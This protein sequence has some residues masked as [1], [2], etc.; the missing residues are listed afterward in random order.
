MTTRPAVGLLGILS[1]PSDAETAAHHEAYLGHVGQ[2][3]AAVTDIIS[4]RPVSSEPELELSIEE[5]ERVGAHGIALVLLGAGQSNDCAE[6]LARTHL[7]LLLV[8]VQPERTVS[9]DWSEYDLH[10]NR[11]VDAVQELA[12]RLVRSRMSFSVI[13]GDWLSDR[14]AAAFE[15]WALA[16]RT[17]PTLTAAPLVDLP[18]R[19]AETLL[20]EAVS[21]RMLAMD[22]NRDAVLLAPDRE[23][24]VARGPLTTAALT[25]HA[26][27]P[28]I[29]VGSGDALDGSELP[30]IKDHQL[31][32][33]PHSGVEAFLDHWLQLGA[34]AGFTIAPGD[35]R[36]R[37]R[38]LAEV[39]AI[40]YEEI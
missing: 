5:L 1:G 15:D 20:A 13:T 37:W 3:L 27:R 35:Q 17:L 36:G 9:A 34:P 23:L 28:R 14:F 6:T 21:C 8:N 33:A 38:R 40:D 26:D 4:G 30:G 25:E 39:L 12:N 22:W 18:R 10:F 19:A 11:A 24:S 29:V 31:L 16:A 7:P 32:F 2:R